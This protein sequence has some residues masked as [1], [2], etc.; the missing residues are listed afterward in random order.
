[1]YLKE[2]KELESRL[3]AMLP[4]T[5]QEKFKAKRRIGMGDWKIISEIRTACIFYGV[6]KIQVTDVNVNTIGEKDVDLV[7]RYKDE[8]IYIEVKG[9]DPEDYEVAKKGGILDLGDNIIDRALKRARPKFILGTPNIVAIADE[10]TTKPSLFENGL[11][12]LSRTPELY[13]E[14]PEYRN[15]SALMILGGY[16]EEQL[17]S[18]Q[19]WHN[20]NALCELSPAL[21][22][23]FTEKA[24]NA[25]QLLRAQ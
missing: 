22:A 25:K 21:H 10:N 8:T 4:D 2:N 13:L 3:L 1:M 19:F 11:S 20:N 7:A 15:I 17:F 9:F 18:Y 23:I 6:L 5:L 14:K 12:Q 16:Y 24:S